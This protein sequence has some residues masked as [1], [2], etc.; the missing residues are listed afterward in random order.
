MTAKEIQEIQENVLEGEGV[1]LIAWTGLEAACL[2]VCR[3]YT[4]TPHLLYSGGGIIRI[5]MTR[6]G[7]EEDDAIEFLEF[8]YGCAWHG[9]GTPAILSDY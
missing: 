1:S 7:M 6:D 5:L 2:G 3:V 9:E 8:N 4:K